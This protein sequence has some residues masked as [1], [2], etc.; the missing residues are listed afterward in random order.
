MST[1]AYSYIRFST[2]RQIKGNSLRRQTERATALCD[3]HG[4]ILTQ[5]PTRIWA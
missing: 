2:K 3:K 1:H 5:C 4:W